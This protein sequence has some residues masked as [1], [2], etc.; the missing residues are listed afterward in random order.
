MVYKKITYLIINLRLNIWKLNQ[1]N[2]FIINNDNNNDINE[3][4]IFFYF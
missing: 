1:I 4:L 3:F 2:E